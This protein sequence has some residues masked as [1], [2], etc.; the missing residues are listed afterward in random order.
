MLLVRYI[1]ALPL[2]LISARCIL[3]TFPLG[4]LQLFTKPLYENLTPTYR[5]FFKSYVNIDCFQKSLL[6][7]SSQQ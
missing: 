7:Y 5:I 3:Y 1:S 4:D 6:L 2:P